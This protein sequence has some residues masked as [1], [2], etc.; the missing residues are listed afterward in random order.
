MPDSTPLHT[1]VDRL[2]DRLR[3]LPASRLRRVAPA[4]LALARDLSV[5]AQR[6][7]LPDREPRLMPDDGIYVVADQLAVA[8][9]EL[10]AALAAHSE[11]HD[12]SEDALRKVAEVASLL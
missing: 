5:T 2:A 11:R 4:G 6:L 9:H 3:A 8:G 1:A 10:S 12:L 7:E